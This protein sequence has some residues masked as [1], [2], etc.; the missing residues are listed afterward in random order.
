MASFASRARCCPSESTDRSKRSRVQASRISAYAIGAARAG[1]RKNQ[2]RGISKRFNSRSSR[3]LLPPP[4]FK[5]S[6]RVGTNSKREI[7]GSGHRGQAQVSVRVQPRYRL[8]A[9]EENPAHRRAHRNSAGRT[10]KS[11]EHRE[12]NSNKA[13]QRTGCAGR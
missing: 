9:I 3:G 8:K 13:L 5:S 2:P 6:C 11:G 4:H 7:C 12:R 10:I 1:S